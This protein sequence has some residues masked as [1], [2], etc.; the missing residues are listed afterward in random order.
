MSLALP[1]EPASA[2]AAR[3]VAGECLRAWHLGR[4]VP[5]VTLVVTEL[6]TNALLHA[7][8]AI[9][10]TVTQLEDGVRVAVRD[11]HAGSPTVRHVDVDSTTGRGL[12][13]V[14]RLARR[15]GVERDSTGKTVWADVDSSAGTGSGSLLHLVARDDP[16]GAKRS[17]GGTHGGTSGS[18]IS[19]RT[20]S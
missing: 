1:P 19:R 7:R 11:G 15:W 6:V 20:V 5:S 13:I 17:G 9:D 18:V 16:D 4:L 2:Q 8:T 12:V 14:A 10:V 3:R